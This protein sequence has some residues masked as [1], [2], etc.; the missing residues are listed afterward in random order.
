ME[1]GKNNL[2][3][4]RTENIPDEEAGIYVYEYCTDRWQSPMN[5]N[6]NER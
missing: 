6:Q 1:Y 3:S 5:N 4:K 2:L